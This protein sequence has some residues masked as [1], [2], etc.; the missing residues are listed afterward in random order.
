MKGLTAEQRKSPL[1]MQSFAKMTGLSV[2]ELQD[3]YML[4][5]D[6]NRQQE[7]LIKIYREQGAAAAANYAAQKG[8]EQGGL[9]IA[10]EK[11]SLEEKYNQALEEAKDQFQA[12]VNGGYINQLQDAISGISKL[13]GWLAPDSAEEKKEKQAEAVKLKKE[14]PALYTAKFAV[15]ADVAMATGGITTGPTNALIGEAGTEAVIPLND[16]YAKLDEVVKA[17][18]QVGQAVK[19]GKN[20]TLHT[21]VNYDANKASQESMKMLTSFA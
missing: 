4:E 1:I 8:F 10:K 20:I 12:F 6:R 14:N 2:D 19:D 11:V 21:K 5:T 3:A 16:F 17:V 15:G 18:N 13:V 7:E 9:A